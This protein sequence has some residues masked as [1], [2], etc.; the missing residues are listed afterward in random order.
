MQSIQAVR[1]PLGDLISRKENKSL[2]DIFGWPVETVTP[3]M[4]KDGVWQVSI[5]N[6]FVRYGM[7]NDDTELTYCPNNWIS[8]VKKQVSFIL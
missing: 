5:Y 1:G 6:R 7:R 2:Q 8:R 4:G 3:M